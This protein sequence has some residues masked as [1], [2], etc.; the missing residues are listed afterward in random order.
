[1][2]RLVPYS[3]NKI[4]YCQF[5]KN[6][7]YQNVFKNHLQF[8][9]NYIK[10]INKYRKSIE[11]K[12]S[13][14]KNISFTK[15]PE[16]FLSLIKNKKVIIVGPSIT[17]QECNL[18]S[19]INNFD[20]VVR[21][22]KSLP[23]PIKMHP[24]IGN[25]TDI[26]YNSLNITDFPGENKFDPYF[27][28]KQKVKYLRCPYPPI[29]PFTNDIKSF[30][31]KNKNTVDFGHIDT[32]YYIKLEHSLGTRPYTGTCAIAD[33][34]HC[35]VKELFV[36]GIDF[37]T[38]KHSFYYRNISERKLQ[39]LR[40][41][42]IHRRKPQIN[43]LR[44]F[45]LLDNR[46]IVDNI[47]DEILLENYDS[48]LYGIKTNIDFE[49]IFITGTGEYINN[50]NLIN[51]ICI[52]GD[53]ERK[54]VN[55]NKIDTIID[56]FPERETPLRNKK[57]K[58]VY[59]NV[60]EFNYIH[61]NKD[62]IFTQVYKNTIDSEFQKE[63]FLFINPIFT[64]YLKVILTKTIFSRGT[65]SLELFI[66]LVFSVFFENVFISSVDPNCNWLNQSANEKQHY[67]EQR[68]L[69]QF[70]LKREKIKYL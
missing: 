13:Y 69:F 20:V 41:N 29:S 47:L 48:L 12:P 15:K 6:Y 26:L 53:N 18:G 19:F 55:Y 57:I 51:S 25:R 34:L 50:I 44:R 61:S 27:L 68:M 58:Y 63:N 36:M 45:Y 62:I 70:L 5:C 40:N 1:M 23:I 35:G 64:Q 42:N 9:T 28:K 37:Y 43:L 16:I 33:L 67:I 52:V 39:K 21:L 17:V 22:N 56:L 2:N 54:K 32:N 10:Y 66:T 65:L 7:Y 30:Y 49:K 38:Y 24:H 60:S 14:H 31:R 59:R 11:W 3:N 46:L 8:C 4:I